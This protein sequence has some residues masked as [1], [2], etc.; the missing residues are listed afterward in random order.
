MSGNLFGNWVERFGNAKEALQ[1][2]DAALLKARDYNLP[3]TFCYKKGSRVC[4]FRR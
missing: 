2:S 1:W 3:G 4:I